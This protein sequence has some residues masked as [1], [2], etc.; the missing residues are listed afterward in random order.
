[1]S[2]TQRLFRLGVFGC[3]LVA[4]SLIAW[5]QL[6][7][8]SKDTAAAPVAK[9]GVE[10]AEVKIGPVPEVLEATGKIL[11]S[12][13]VEIR[14]QVGGQ[15]KSVLIKDGDHIEI[16]QPLFEIDDIPLKAALALAEAQWQKDKALA[17]NALDTETRLRPLSLT[18]ATT[19]KDYVTAV[20]TRISLQGAA[21]ASKAQIEQAHIALGYSRIVS[22]IAGRAG[23]ILVKA[24]NLLSTATG[25]VPLVVINSVTPAEVQFSIPQQAFEHLRLAQ[26]RE[27]LTVEIRDTGHTKLRARG[28]LA[29]LDNAFNDLSGT[30]TLKARIPNANEELWPGEFVA[31]RVLLR[32]EPEALSVPEVA[33]QQGQNGPYVY[34]ADAGK[35]KIQ[36]VKVARIIDG[37]AVIAEGLSTGQSVLT[38]IPTNL[39]DGSLIDVRANAAPLSTPVAA[40]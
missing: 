2:S 31:V 22:P 24:G 35:A 27:P 10:V 1:M 8:T 5:S 32:T 28:T 16:G 3:V 9:L 14:A 29:F 18:G 36:P 33:L 34:V 7:R 17:D 20:N 40:R 38:R 4:G 30:I 21:D 12:A 13:S 39:R 15:L 26:S 23:A 11:A 25:T 37:R 6:G 19:K